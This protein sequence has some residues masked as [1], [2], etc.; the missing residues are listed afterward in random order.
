MARQLR[1]NK[2]DIFIAFKPNVS[3]QL[4][5]EVIHACQIKKEKGM[6][7]LSMEWSMKFL[8]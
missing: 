1:T 5:I 3:Y 7:N 6:S 8:V 2:N 4:T